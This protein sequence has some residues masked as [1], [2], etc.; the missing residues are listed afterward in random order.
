MIATKIV[1]LIL[2]KHL[3]NEKVVKMKYVFVENEMFV[4]SNGS[5]KVAEIMLWRGCSPS[6]TILVMIRHFPFS[7][8]I[9]QRSFCPHCSIF[10]LLLCSCIQ[11]STNS[12]E[13]RQFWR[14]RWCP[15]LSGQKCAVRYSSVLRVSGWSYPVPPVWR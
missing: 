5:K 4:F 6:Q 3:K 13:R 1:S 10:L 15:A 14:Y 8:I 9:L 11:R 2:I 7:S 12:A